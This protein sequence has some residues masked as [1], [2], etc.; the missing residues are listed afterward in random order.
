MQWGLERGMFMFGTRSL[1]MQRKSFIVYSTWAGW[2]L[3]TGATTALAR[4]LIAQYSSHG[5]RVDVS[6]ERRQHEGLTIGCIHGIIQMSDCL[7]I[8]S[9][10]Y[11]WQCQRCRACQV[12]FLKAGQ[13]LPLKCSR[14]I[15]HPHMSNQCPRR[16]HPPSSS[17]SSSS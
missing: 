12:T 15:Y 16:I 1:H 2:P 5:A 10:R 3:A 4:D 7:M 8:P 6:S 11:I 13:L 17:S 14:C 9:E